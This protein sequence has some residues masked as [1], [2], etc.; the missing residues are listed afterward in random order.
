VKPNLKSVLR[1][2]H[3]PLALLL[4]LALALGLVTVRH[5]GE[6]WDEADI[7][8]YS[9]YALDAYRF[10]ARPAALPP[11]DTNLNLYGPGYYMAANVLTGAITAVMPAWSQVNAWHVLYFVTFLAGAAALYLLSLRW[12]SALS[13]CGVTLLFLS[14]PLL[15][16][17]AFINPKDI[18]FM[19]FFTV[20]VFL[21][22]RM[23][24][25][26]PRLHRPVASVLLP[27]ILLGLT[28]SFRVLGPL[29]GLIVLAYAARQLGSKAI[30]LAPVYVGV[31]AATTYLSWPYLWGAPFNRYVEALS[32]MAHFP[33]QLPT[34]FAG[35]Q[36]L[37]DQ[38]PTLYFPVLLGIQW[39]EPAL[40]LIGSGLLIS[41]WRFYK[42]PT[43]GPLALFVAWF[44]VPA[45]FIIWSGSTLYDNARQLFFLFPPLFL[46]AGVA[47]EKLFVL[48]SHP[49]AK[50]AVLLL[51]ALPG[52]WSGAR[53]HPYEY[54]YYNALVGG[55]RGAAGRFELDYWGTSLQ[56][57]AAFL[58]SSA[59]QRASVVVYGPDWVIAHYARPD[60]QVHSFQDVA[61]TSYDYIVLLNRPLLNEGHCKAAETVFSVQRDAAVL[62]VLKSAPQGSRCR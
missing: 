55:T 4:A 61:T 6:S 58:N 9:R 15:W 24:D 11:F 48:L 49:A 25:N 16:G 53:L 60:I 34:V 8:R 44:L 59:P 45:A 42:Q 29:S 19:A 43:W 57:I 52:I 21:G 1:G 20:T 12:M 23:I 10:L 2:R 51:A 28:S 39:T 35:N 7:Y 3:V 27:A 32:I 36:Y 37:P 26:Y 62:S 5:Y 30:V 31:A 41:I 56:D 38:L 22:F 17:H 33:F 14:Q 46:L 50:A 54:V 18:P 40:V 47:F 13:A